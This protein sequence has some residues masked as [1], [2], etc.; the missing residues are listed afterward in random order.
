MPTYTLRNKDTGKIEER[1]MSIS[2]K[3][4]LV[5]QGEFEQIHTKLA[6]IVSTRGSIL[7][8]TSG[9]WKDLLKRTKKGSG[10]GNTINT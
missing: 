6:S 8:Q 7:G 4:A 1:I 2:S 10:K 9:D 3:E 5:E